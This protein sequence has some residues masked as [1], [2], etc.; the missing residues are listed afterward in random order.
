M[1]F[2]QFGLF[3]AWNYNS[4]VINKFFLIVKKNGVSDSNSLK[5]AYIGLILGS[6]NLFCQAVIL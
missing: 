3:I 2:D 6:R 5:M 4:K 1:K